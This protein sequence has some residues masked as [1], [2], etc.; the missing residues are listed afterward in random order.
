[1]GVF[2]GYPKLENGIRKYVPKQVKIAIRGKLKPVKPH[3]I[4]LKTAKK[5]YNKPPLDR[6]VV[7]IS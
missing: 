7:P 3:D 2:G 5:N 6:N 1:M 4:F